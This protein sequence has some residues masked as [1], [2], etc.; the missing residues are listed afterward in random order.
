MLTTPGQIALVIFTG[1]VAPMIQF[2]AKTAIVELVHFIVI[3]IVVIWI[4]VVALST[5]STALVF[6]GFETLFHALSIV[7]L[8]IQHL[9]G[10]RLNRINHYLFLNYF[11]LL[12]DLDG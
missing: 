2:L 12:V 11:P 1:G 9:I 5:S 10:Q 8:V 6:E 3:V 4:D 7:S